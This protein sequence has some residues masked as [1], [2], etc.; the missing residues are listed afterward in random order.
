MGRIIRGVY[1]S[2]RFTKQI[3]CGLGCNGARAVCLAC[4][5]SLERINMARARSDGGVLQLKTV[6]LE[7][8]PFED[9]MLAD[10]H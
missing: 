7:R 5:E 1:S 10:M 4:Q 6:M 9:N 2:K 8:L 3:G